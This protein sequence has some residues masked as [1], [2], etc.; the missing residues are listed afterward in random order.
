[1]PGQKILLNPP[2]HKQKKDEKWAA[3]NSFCFPQPILL[4]N[5]RKRRSGGL[6]QGHMERKT[7]IFSI[8]DFLLLHAGRGAEKSVKFLHKPIPHNKQ[9][10]NDC[11]NDYR[12]HNVTFLS[13]LLFYCV[14][15][16]VIFNYIIKD[17]A[18]VL[19]WRLG[20]PVKIL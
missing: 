18:L 8:Q 20:A 9:K 7:A 19:D 3:E 6:F 13:W 11:N 15:L 5:H 17:S 14:S 2:Y 16:V 12:C 4:Q 10:T 1:M